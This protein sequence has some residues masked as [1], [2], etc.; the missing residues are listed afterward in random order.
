MKYDLVNE[1]LK[2]HSKMQCDKIVARVGN[3]KVRFNE[4][5]SVFLKG[6][7]RLTQRAAWPLSYCIQNHP[8]LIEPHLK[9]ILTFASAK[10]AHVSVRRN[11]MRLLQFIDIP[12]KYHGLT[13]DLCFRFLVDKKE[14]VAVR[15]F[16][17]TVLTNL[18]KEIPELKQEIIPIIE[19]NLPYESAGFISRG[20]KLLKVLRS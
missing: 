11:I 2:E 3:S 9:T 18:S 12:K 1:I 16:A 6:P 8:H 19:D 14:A 7:Y 20:K 5:V 4:L 13:V 15:V 17:M 10:G